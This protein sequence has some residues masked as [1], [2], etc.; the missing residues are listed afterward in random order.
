M[1]TFPITDQPN[2]APE[3]NQIE[4]FAVRW[5]GATGRKNGN[6]RTTP[7]GAQQLAR[8]VAA[9]GAT[10]ISITRYWIAGFVF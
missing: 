7:G 8:K 10:E 9:A 6:S 4:Q 3:Q 1:K 5:V 2:P